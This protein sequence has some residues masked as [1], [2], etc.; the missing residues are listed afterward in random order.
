[1]S[2]RIKMRI[3]PF[4]PRS[5]FVPDDWLE[6]HH[7][8]KARTIV[9]GRGVCLLILRALELNGGKLQNGIRDNEVICLLTRLP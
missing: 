9:Q 4:E 7:E 2:N 3:I 1:M 8:G 5:R 6:I